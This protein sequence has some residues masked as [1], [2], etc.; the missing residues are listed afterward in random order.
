MM[1]AHLLAV[2]PAD[3]RLA[4]DDVEA[5]G[6]YH[7]RCREGAS[8]HALA[9]GAMVQWQAIVS[10]GASPMRN[11]ILP[12]RQPPSIGRAHLATHGRLLPVEG[13]L[14]FIV[15]R[16]SAA[17]RLD[18][19]Y[20]FHRD[21]QRIG[22]FRKV[23]D[24]ACRAIGLEGRVAASSMTYGGAGSAT[25]SALVSRRT[26]SW[27]CRVTAR[28]PCSSGTTSSASMIFAKRLG[29]AASTAA[30]RRRPS[31]RSAG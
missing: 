11:R 31:P 22:D 12:Q 23:W 15:E 18:C 2:Q 1:V 3:H 8:G 16:R 4:R 7:D 29:G 20:V 10:N 21:G 6:R 30:A 24:R 14:A 27:R 13:A 9:A 5:A 28:H 26:P 25:S 19:P 17:R